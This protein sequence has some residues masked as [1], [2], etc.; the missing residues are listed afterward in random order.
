MIPGI[1]TKAFPKSHVELCD[2]LSGQ[3]V[4]IGCFPH[5][6]YESAPMISGSN[7][8]IPNETGFLTLGIQALQSAIQA[9]LAW[10]FL[11]ELGYLESS[12]EPFQQEVFRLF[13]QKH[14]LAVL[15]GQPTP[16]LD[17]LRSRDDVF[18]YDLDAPVLPLGCVIMASGESRRF[19]SN[20]LLTPFCGKPMVAHILTAV[21]GSLLSDC[22]VVTRHP[23]IQSICVECRTDVLLH[24]YPHKND[25]IRLG[26]TALLERNPLSG[27]MFAVSDQPLL[28]TETINTLLLSFS[29]L[30]DTSAI[31]RPACTDFPGS[32]ILFGSRYFNELL[33]LPEGKGGRFVAQKYPQ[34]IRYISTKY[35]EELLDADTPE[36]LQRLECLRQAFR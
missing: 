31:Y 5:S 15:R 25:T 3:T 29:Q 20:K 35:P 18:L 22:I 14:V 16:F 34:N 17:A 27:C 21:S 9:D 19:G 13:E 32:P 10:S 33:T 11:D 8:M 6:E 2:N 24:D 23:E 26:L 12:C 36:A 28:T 7:Q 4:T 1:T 30:R